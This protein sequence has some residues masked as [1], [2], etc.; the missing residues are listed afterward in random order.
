[1]NN[2]CR[3]RIACFLFSFI[4]AEFTELIPGAMAQQNSVQD[5]SHLKDAQSGGKS[6][7]LPAVN[8]L[9]GWK[10]GSVQALNSVADLQKVERPEAVVMLGIQNA[11]LRQVPAVLKRFPNIT[12]LDLSHN[13]LDCETISGL[14]PPRSLKKIYLNN[15]KIDE[16]CQDKLKSRHPA[17]QFTFTIPQLTQKPE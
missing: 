2:K 6:P 15:N 3:F 8:I 5:M 4:L 10:E 17:I 7:E 1:M 14:R 16:A 9:V 11:E 12:M 13:L